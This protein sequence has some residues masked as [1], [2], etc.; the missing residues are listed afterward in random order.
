MPVGVARV[1]VGDLAEA[2]YLHVHLPPPTSPD[3]RPEVPV[4]LVD[5]RDADA[6]RAALVG[7]VEHSLQRVTMPI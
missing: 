5:G 1:L 4:V 6:A 7:L 2:G 3:G